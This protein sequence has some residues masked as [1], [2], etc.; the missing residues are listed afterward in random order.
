MD[1]KT[2]LKPILY[3]MFLIFL[4]DTVAQKL[5]WYYSIWWFDMP[6]HFFGGFWE[7]LLFM[8]FFS[9][10]FLPFSWLKVHIEQFDLKLIIKTLSFVFVIGILWEFF[11]I[12]THNYLGL[13]PFNIVDT[14]SDIFFDLAGGAFAILYFFKRIM[15]SSL[16]KVQ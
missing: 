7:G 14:T 11:E 6:M 2:L 16:N 12:Y 10:D 5:Y 9:S 3:F 13:D 1:R 8:W 15:G 4:A